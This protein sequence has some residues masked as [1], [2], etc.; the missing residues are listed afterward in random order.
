MDAKEATRDIATSMIEEITTKFRSVLE[1][2]KEPYECSYG[3]LEW[4]YVLELKHKDFYE[5]RW[6]ENK[7][8]KILFTPDDIKFVHWYPERIAYECPWKDP[9]TINILYDFIQN[10]INSI[11]NRRMK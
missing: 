2:I 10:W 3:D 1:T 4:S 11:E 5:N 9:S 6:G 8:I 7:Y